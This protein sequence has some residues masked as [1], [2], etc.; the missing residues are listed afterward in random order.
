M[1]VAVWASIDRDRLREGGCTRYDGRIRM[2]IDGG[3]D[4]RHARSENREVR[5][6]GGRTDRLPV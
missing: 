6:A 5:L 3:G 2:T 4:V 1:P